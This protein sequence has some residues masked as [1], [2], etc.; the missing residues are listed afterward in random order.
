M[1]M[2]VRGQRSLQHKSQK[3]RQRPLSSH[4]RVEHSQTMQNMPPA[5]HYSENVAAVEVHQAYQPYSRPTSYSPSRCEQPPSRSKGAADNNI[6]KS[7]LNLTEQSF[8]SNRYN[9]I[10]Q[11][12]D[13]LFND[14]TRYSSCGDISK[15]PSKVIYPDVLPP[16]LAFESQVKRRCRRCMSL[17][18]LVTISGSESQY[19]ES[20]H[21]SLSTTLQCMRLSPHG[22]YYQIQPT[23]SAQRVSYNVSDTDESSCCATLVQGNHQRLQRSSSWQIP[24]TNHASKVVVN[25]NNNFCHKKPKSKNAKGS[26]AIPDVGITHEQEQR[27]YFRNEAVRVHQSDQPY[28]MPPPYSGNCSEQSTS[29]SK[30]PTDNNISKLNLTSTEQSFASYK[31]DN[32]QPQS[33]TLLNDRTRYSSCGDISTKS[34]K[35][36]HPDVLPPYYVHESQGTESHYFDTSHESLVTKVGSENYS[37]D[38]SDSSMSRSK[39]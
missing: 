8:A 29:R 18:S 3:E 16:Q 39:Y 31:Y 19:S 21:K 38:T 33:D 26:R 4:G 15:N 17:E 7:E 27:N 25:V 1:E 2:S 23:H 13:T 20:S 34:K 6:S 5:Q 14:R 30:R 36:I 37:S 24:T 11:Q 12:T 35:V 22:R 9:Y 28:S 10:Q 32:M